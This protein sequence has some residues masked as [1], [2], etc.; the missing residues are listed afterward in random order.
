VKEVRVL[1]GNKE[2]RGGIKSAEEGSVQMFITVREIGERVSQ[3]LERHYAEN[4]RRIF[5]EMKLRGFVPN[6]MF[7]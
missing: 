6:F 5:P 2:C 3:S 7:R 4:S 1:L